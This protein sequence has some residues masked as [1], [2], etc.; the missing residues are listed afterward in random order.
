MAGV[1]L[2]Q[3]IGAKHRVFK[4]DFCGMLECP[5]GDDY[6]NTSSISSGL[7]KKIKSSF[8]TYGDYSLHENLFLLEADM[9]SSFS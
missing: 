1:N 8:W 5:D 7:K 3:N 2:P 6:L 4:T 9:K